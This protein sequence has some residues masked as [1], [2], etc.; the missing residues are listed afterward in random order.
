MV[1]LDRYRGTEVLRAEGGV[2]NKERPNAARSAQ[3]AFRNQ[4]SEFSAI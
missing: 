1:E 4:Q 2:L 3:S